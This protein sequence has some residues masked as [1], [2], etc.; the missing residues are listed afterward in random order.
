MGYSDPKYYARE[1]ELLA[2]SS[3]STGTYTAGSANTLATAIPLPRFERRQKVLTVKVV[4]KT[5]SKAGSTG[6]VTLN[7]L[8]GTATFAVATV[9]TG[10]AGTE[11][12]V[13][14]TAN[15]TF[16]AS[17][18]ATV[19]VLGTATASGDT[20]GAYELFFETQELYDKTA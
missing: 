15:N 14:P 11:V 8:N 6:P 4:T 13:V 9:G 3:I 20:F 2:D 16:T 12:V 18:S 19:T 7:F 1:I 5:P 10:T 17:G